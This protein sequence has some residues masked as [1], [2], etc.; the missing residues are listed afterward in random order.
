MP[1][2]GLLNPVLLHLV[3]KRAVADVE[4]LRRPRAIRLRELERAAD[5]VLLEVAHALLQRKWNLPLF[6]LLDADRGSG[7]EQVGRKVVRGDRLAGEDHGW[8][9]GMLE[10]A[11]VARPAVV[12]QHAEGRL[13]NFRLGDAVL[14]G[15]LLE[16]VVNEKRD[17]LGAIA[18]RGQLD[19]EDVQP[20]EKI[21]AKS[22]LAHF[23]RQVLYR[24]RDD[25][26]VD[27]G[28]HTAADLADFLFL[29]RPQELHLQR[30]R[31]LTDL[32]EKERA[33]VR[34]LEEPLLVANRVRE[35]SFDVAEELA[36]EE[37]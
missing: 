1:E 15:V 31:Q 35:R 4:Q 20:V 30:E 27:P 17:V 12:E 7:R 32:V 36:L 29:K 25:S 19:R 13:G 18:K 8:L 28:W 34:H 26:H 33:G 5:Q 23:A 21:V 2:V 16:E 14:T 6:R 10:L 37:F 9:D 3:E 11:H 24:R 22:S